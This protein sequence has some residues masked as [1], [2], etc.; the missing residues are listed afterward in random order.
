MA[1]F[2][3]LLVLSVVAGF[4]RL[5]MWQLDRAQ[6]KRDAYAHFRDNNARPVTDLQDILEAS[7]QRLMWRKVRAHGQYLAGSNVLLD[8]QSHAGQPGYLVFT[9]MRLRAPAETVVLVNRGWIP[10]GRTREVVELPPFPAEPVTV[11]AQIGAAP[12]A[13]IRLP[14]ARLIERL[15][16]GTLRVQL[17]DYAALGNALGVS[18]QPFV[19]LLDPEVAHGFTRD[20]SVPGGDEARHRSYAVQWFALAAAL[21]TIYVILLLK[22]NR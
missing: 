21:L 2:G 16:G 4:V 6:Q 17:I 15:A 3:G 8:N 7:P 13:G 5:G 22:S 1:V 12:A 14:G 11:T 10:V 18:L 9:A 19:L 20:W